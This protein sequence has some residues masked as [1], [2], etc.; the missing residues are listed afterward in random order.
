MVELGVEFIFLDFQTS[1][2]FGYEIGWYYFSLLICILGIL[3]SSI[4][5]LDTSVSVKQH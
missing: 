5:V 1:Q 4:N 3:E 2:C